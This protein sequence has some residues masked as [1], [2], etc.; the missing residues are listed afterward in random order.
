MT[1]PS[2]LIYGAADKPPVSVCLLSACQLLT[3]VAPLMIYPILVMRETGAGDQAVAQMIS[4]SFLIL[5]FA[6]PLQALRQRW[7]GSGYLISAAPAAVYVPVGIAAIA[8]GGMP[9]LMGMTLL[10]GLL[11][12][13]FAQIVRRARAFFPAEVSGLCILLIGMIIGI[14][15]L[16]AIFGIDQGGVAAT[17]S[18]QDLTL[19]AATLALMIGFTLWGKGALR[20]YCAAIGVAAGYV[21]AL[22]LGAANPDTTALVTSA[23]LLAW[24]KWAYQ[25][26]AFSADLIVPFAVAALTCALRAMGDISAA[27]KINDREW[28]RPDMTSIRNGIIANGA[29][30]IIAALAGG[31]GGNTQS[32]SVGMSNATGVAS[33]WVAYWLGGLLVALS[34]F[35]VAA[36]VLVA[37]PRPVIG[38]SLLFTSCF[39][40]VSGLQVVTSRLLDPRRTFVIG[41]ALILSL[42]HDLFPQL[43]GGLPFQFQPFVGSGLAIGLISALLLNAI[44]RIGVRNTAAITI[45]PDASAHD[46]VRTFLEQRGASWGA[47]RDVME[48]AIFGT[49]QSIESIAEH[50]NV[51]GPVTVEASFDE[52]NLD[53]RLSYLGDALVIPDR[54]PTDDEIR[55]TEDGVRLL[56]G[57]LIQRNADRV[58]ASRKADR[59]V[60]EFH[61][62]H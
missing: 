40:L 60:L 56:A 36:A 35:P 16:R 33:R 62:Q 17:A 26:P 39:V 42:S 22:L 15:G 45:E 34:F 2:Y 24:P 50:C 28:I 21:A 51:Q 44:F 29:G 18:A 25:L 11:E 20:M 53:I 38:A 7:I 27:Q 13:A 32:S 49:A 30:T 47:R 57:Y 5:G 54:R 52:F 14:L 48:R 4:L 1:R 19:S 6:T 55:E 46:A 58:R 8:A 3:V 61:F 12:I 9:L 10:A 31:L 43:Y 37:T 59:A 41:L 23:P